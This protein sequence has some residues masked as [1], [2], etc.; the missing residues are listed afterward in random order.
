MSL[1]AIRQ[2]GRDTNAIMINHWT[3]W[4][5]R[6]LIAC[7]LCSVSIVHPDE[8]GHRLMARALL[9]LT[10]LWDPD[11]A[12]CQVAVFPCPRQ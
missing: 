7:G 3:E 4:E 2:I 11:S 10:T 5:P 6:R 9:K 8:Y 12:V 1:D